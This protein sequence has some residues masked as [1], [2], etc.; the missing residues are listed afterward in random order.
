MSDQVQTLS[1][2]SYGTKTKGRCLTS[3]RTN[4][5]VID[6]P[7][8]T[9]GPNEA[10]TAGEAFFSGI[11]GCA[12]LMLER[13]SRE[14][15]YLLGGIRVDLEATRDIENSSAAYALYD[16]IRLDFELSGVTKSQAEELIGIYKRR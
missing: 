5:F 2:R 13:L 8:Y 10:I 3:A 14:K 11:T 16:H 1:V 9:G 15:D 7:A 4:H 6:D 12:V